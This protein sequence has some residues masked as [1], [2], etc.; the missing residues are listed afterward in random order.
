MIDWMKHFLATVGFLSDLWDYV[1]AAVL[2]AAIVLV[3]VGKLPG[4][5]LIWHT[6]F[7]G[8]VLG[9][10]RALRELTVCLLTLRSVGWTHV[11]RPQSR[12]RAV[13]L[14][15]EMAIFEPRP[16]YAFPHGKP[17]D[18]AF[19]RGVLAWPGPAAKKWR[20]RRRRALDQLVYGTKPVEISVATCFELHDAKPAITRYFE[21]LRSDSA[22]EA[23]RFVSTLNIQTAYLAPLHLVAGLLPNFGDD[24]V[25]V[26]DDFGQAMTRSDDP[27][28]GTELRSIQAFIFDCW[29]IWGPSIPVCKCHRWQGGMEALQLGYGDE[30]NSIPLVSKPDVLFPRFDALLKRVHD[31]PGRKSP[32]PIALQVAVVG[33]PAWVPLPDPTELSDEDA[34]EPAVNRGQVPPA[35]QGIA[36]GLVLDHI[37]VNLFGGKTAENARLYYSAYLW[38]IFVI[39]HPDGRPLFPK[40]ESKP[41]NGEMWRG[42][43]TFFEHGNVA[44]G[45]AYDFMK[46]QLAR[47]A[48]A[49]LARLVEHSQPSGWRFAY[50]CAFDDP[51][52]GAGEDT[53][54]FPESASVKSLRQLLEEKLQK[55]FATL[56]STGRVNVGPSTDPVYSAC[57][58]TDTI[59][60]FYRTVDAE[61]K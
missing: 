55:E 52:C 53:R 3:L 44:D 20:A 40:T 16:P 60:D 14:W 34:T 45:V 59:Q 17:W 29:L 11:F 26:I 47:K 23:D 57:D 30:N 19:W 61:R 1:K 48:L 49:G 50:M 41:N 8:Q 5:R 6:L 46:E 25:P 4:T 10:I 31:V 12:R 28:R 15:V 42:L 54:R 38:I 32:G 56:A 7:R 21:T 58:L 51:G 9:P 33:R 18:A 13:R 22:D 27:L 37:D 39:Q 35:L 43:L 2:V 24:W 36:G